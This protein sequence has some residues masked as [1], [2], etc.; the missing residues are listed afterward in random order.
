MRTEFRS[1]PWH[2]ST[3]RW[4]IG[5]H[6][7]RGARRTTSTARGTLRLCRRKRRRHHVAAFELGPLPTLLP[8]P[9]DIPPYRA[10]IRMAHSR[11]GCCHRN[12]A[13]RPRPAHH[14]TSSRA[15]TDADDL[16]RQ[17]GLAPGFLEYSRAALRFPLGSWDAFKIARALQSS[18]AAFLAATGIGRWARRRAAGGHSR[19]TDTHAVSGAPRGRGCGKGHLLR[20]SWPCGLTSEFSVL[21]GRGAFQYDGEDGEGLESQ[22]TVGFEIDRI[23]DLLSEGWSVI[24]T[25]SARLVDHPD[26]SSNTP[27][28]G[29]CRGRGEPG[30]QSWRSPPTR[31]RDESSSTIGRAN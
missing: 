14:P 5:I 28:T 30:G 8:G 7:I 10:K 9:R 26:G 31:S 16:A 6:S 24:V 19:T 11:H 21:G 1:R 12:R 3:S 4:A 27:S 29:S 2:R 15:W 18:P 23:D 22:G 25:G 13:W 20:S 17:A